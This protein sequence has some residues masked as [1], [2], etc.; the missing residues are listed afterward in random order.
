[1]RRFERGVTLPELLIVLAIISVLALVFVVRMSTA[2]ATA[3]DDSAQATARGIAAAISSYYLANACYPPDAPD[4]TG[5]QPG[6][7]NAMPSGMQPYVNQWPY[8]IAWDWYNCCGYGAIYWW[9]SSG[10]WVREAIFYGPR[11]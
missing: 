2:R 6:G 7:P 8:G 9:R 5:S 4:W 10:G 1:M 11:C 3:A